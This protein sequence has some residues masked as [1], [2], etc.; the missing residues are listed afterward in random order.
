[1]T[2]TPDFMACLGAKG[3]DPSLDG[4]V[5]DLAGE[6]LTKL[7]GARPT[8]HKIDG[9]ILCAAPITGGQS[10]VH[11]YR[12]L[13][14]GV[15]LPD[16]IRA[17]ETE[18]RAHN[19]PAPE[20]ATDRLRTAAQALSLMPPKKRM[21]Q[22]L[23]AI[24]DA[25]ISGVAAMAHVNNGKITKLFF[26]NKSAVNTRDELGTV[27]EAP[28]DQDINTE[29][30]L[31]ARSMGG[32]TGSLLRPT[33][34]K[35]GL[36]FFGVDL[37]ASHK[38]A[39][40]L[41]Q[42]FFA[43]L[44]DK[45]SAKGRT[46]GGLWGLLAAACVVAAT[47]FLMLPAPV[48]VSNFAQARASQTMTISLP[49]GAFLEDTFVL[50]GDVL[51]AGDTAA[52][53]R[54]PEIENGIAEQ[55]VTHSLELINAQDALNTGNLGEFQLAEKRAEIALLRL[56][57]LQSQQQQ[58]VVMAPL[59]SRVVT[60][61]PEGERG[62]FLPIGSPVV[63]FQPTAAFDVLI[64]VAPADAALLE[65]G[66]T[67]HVFFRGLS[68][69]TFPLEIISAPTQTV[70]PDTGETRDQVRARLMTDGQADL[71]VGLSG[72]AKIETRTAPRIVGLTRPLVDYMRLLVWKTLGFTF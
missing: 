34:P 29:L 64:D 66:Q 1:M 45:T 25:G 39:L 3:F 11:G 21:G 5:P 4:E 48:Y 46:F 7:L 33:N 23:Y 60:T 6:Q 70:N 58:L 35:N 72:F 51:N 55:T 24:R 18:A 15:P 37:S 56:D 67:G 69:E 36:V 16:L 31:I 8:A 63:T 47:V 68:D 17:V 53:L 12:R 71:L 41:S 40:T 22:A 19:A 13:P 10:L 30:D 28:E 38:S 44:N 65:I 57:Q 27:V 43:L 2:P 14:K 61:L 49:F 20:D 54:S 52:T 59:D 50:P 62:N 42:D 32:T 26:T 9:W